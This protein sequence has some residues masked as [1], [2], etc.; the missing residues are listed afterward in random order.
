MIDVNNEFIC[1]RKIRQIFCEN[2][3]YGVA[4]LRKIGLTE[5]IGLNGLI[6][7]IKRSHGTRLTAHGKRSKVKGSRLSDIARQLDM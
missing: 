5:L 3:G 7:P 6:E 2:K 1:K 4:L